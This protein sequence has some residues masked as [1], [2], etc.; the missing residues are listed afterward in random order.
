M[1]TIL[2]WGLDCIRL[3]QSSANPTLTII[4]RIITQF[5]STTAYLVLLPLLYWCIDEKKSLRLGTVILISAWVNLSLKFLLDQPRPFFEGYDPSV[6]IIGERMGGFPSG[7]AQNS[8]VMWFI[9]A[10]WAKEKKY[11]RAAI[12]GAAL[13]CLLIGFSRIYLGVHFPTDVFGGWL[14]AGIILCGYF[15]AGKRIEAFFTAHGPRSGLIACAV[16]TFIMILYRPSADILMPGGMLLG[17]GTGYFLCKRY[18]GFSASV[19]VDK[20]GGDTG[21]H[22]GKKYLILF[23]RFV[24]G[25]AGM[26]V[27][28]TALEKAVAIFENTGNYNL[29]VFLHYVLL[30]LWVSAGAPWL[31][32]ILRLAKGIENNQDNA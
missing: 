6:G 11:Y 22:A 2:Q 19:F 23:I 8:L 16:L 13:F 10:S 17:L 29:V 15:L 21:G 24:L 3:I 25:M 31:F 12:G 32:R 14:I 1:E 28:R 30:A 20:S 9:I 18:V 27:L 4:V 5:G 26:V 7:H